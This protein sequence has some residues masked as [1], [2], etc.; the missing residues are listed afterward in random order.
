MRLDQ[1]LV[2]RGLF[3]SRERARRAVMAG[4]IEVDGRRVDKAGTQIADD[5]TLRTLGSGEPFVSRA[6]R[7]LAAALDHFASVHPDA[8]DPR[9]RVCLDVGAS[10][11][12]FTD[13]LLQ[14]GARCVY[15]VDVGY[16]QLDLRLRR[17]PRVVVMERINARHLAPD[18]L[19]EPC[20]L[21]TIDVSFISLTKIVPAL[22]P[23]LAPNGHVLPMIK[24]QFEAGRRQVGKGGIV[25]DPAVR[26]AVI[27]ER[28]QDLEALG[29]RCLGRFDSP[30]T[31]V[32]GNQETFALLRR[33]AVAPAH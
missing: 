15:A 24:P 19:P 12:G 14:R 16:G 13:C 22:L 10:T 20:D 30:V 17:D 33:A 5:A 1:L 8:V 27:A 6:G 31:G 25:R 7:K 2:Q 23:H 21:I 28:V 29:L 3:P 9:E 18:A 4:L 11:G 26:T 32:G